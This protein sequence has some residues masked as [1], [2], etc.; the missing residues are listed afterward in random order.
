LSRAARRG[1]TGGRTGEDLA[2][3]DGR[4]HLGHVLHGHDHLELEGL[5]HPGVDHGDRPGPPLAVVTPSPL[6]S[7]EEAGDLVEGALGGRQP[8]ALRD[9]VGASCETFQALEGQRQ[10]GAALGAGHRVDLVDD[11]VGDRGQHLADGRR[12]HE[13]ERLGGGD[14][15]V[16]R[17]AGDVTAVGLGG[18][19]CA[20]GHRDRRWGQ[21][22]PCRL[23]G[24]AGEGGPQVALDVIGEGLEG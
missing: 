19:A 24:D 13:V 17:V 7:A 5:A 15:D 9:S 10:V 4:A 23:H 20:G 11:H 21:A 22:P 1:V 18:V 16:G 12:E 14:E 8:D 2:V 6:A 3:V